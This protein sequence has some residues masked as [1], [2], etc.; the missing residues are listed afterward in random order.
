MNNL[1]FMQ[2]IIYIFLIF[3]CSNIFAQ[4]GSPYKDRVDAVF[5]NIDKSPTRIPTRLLLETGLNLIQTAKLQG[6]ITADNQVNFQIW[7]AL[8]HNVQ[9]PTCPNH[10]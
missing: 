5:I 2:R 10:Y 3:L 4:S 6:V 8:H 1:I 7:N 9:K